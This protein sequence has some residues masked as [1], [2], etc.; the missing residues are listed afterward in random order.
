M[1]RSAPLLFLVAA[2]GPALPARTP[3]PAL[4]PL[5]LPATEWPDAQRAS[6]TAARGLAVAVAREGVRL[7]LLDT[8][9]APATYTDRALG[10]SPG[11]VPITERVLASLERNT[12]PDDA[13]CARATHVV[14]RVGGDAVELVPV[15]RPRFVADAT[16]ILLEGR[17]GESWSLRADEAHRLC[18][19]PCARWMRPDSVHTLARDGDPARLLVFGPTVPEPS[20]HLAVGTRKDPLWPWLGVGTAVFGAGLTATTIALG[21][22]SL[23]RTRTSTDSGSSGSGSSSIVG[24]LVVGALA[25]AIDGWSIFYLARGPREEPALVPAQ[26]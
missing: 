9:A 7:E 22:S 26:P 20:L 10:A 21:P 8:C 16:R 18:A 6:A 19:L 2:C 25:L 5:T 14:T 17:A 11:G 23:S 12:L 24:L 13:A 1:T 15:V 4:A 3:D